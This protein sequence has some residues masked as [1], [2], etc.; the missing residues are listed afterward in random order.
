[1]RKKGIPDVMH[2][3]VMSLN[4]LQRQGSVLILMCRRCLRLKVS[5]K[6]PRICD[7]TYFAVVVDVSTELARDCVLS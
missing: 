5:V 3:S 7:I 4:E 6:A 1:M 2:R